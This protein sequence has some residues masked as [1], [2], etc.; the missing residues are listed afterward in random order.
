MRGID[1]ADVLILFLWGMDKL[2]RPTLRNLLAGF[3]EFEH[4]RDVEPLLRRLQK[5]ELVQRRGRADRATFMITPKGRQRVRE[6]HPR[7]AWDRRWD[8]LWRVVTFDVPESQ[9]QQRYRLWQALRERKL[10]LLQRSVWIWPR[11]VQPILTEII[12]AEGIPECFCGF[13]SRRLFLCSNEELVAAAWDFEEIARQ[14]TGYL[15]QPTATIK[16]LRSA[17]SLAALARI[18]RAER[19][20]YEYAFALDPLLPRALW[21]KNYRGETVQSQHE[22][23]AAVL[24]GHLAE[25]SAHKSGL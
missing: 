14:Q 5:R 17:R 9:R 22:Q 18:A 4:R 21:P 1:Y 19:I 25:L 7:A 8:R 20:A 6:F 15:H 13:E 23:F 11:D 16:N 24:A 12:H 3:E 10:G 2:T